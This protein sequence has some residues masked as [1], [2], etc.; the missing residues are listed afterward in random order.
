MKNLSPENKHN[1]SLACRPVIIDKLCLVAYTSSTFRSKCH[2]F[3]G[4]AFVPEPGSPLDLQPN[5]TPATQV[6]Y[7]DGGEHI[8][9]SATYVEY[10]HDIGKVSG[11]KHKKT[12]SLSSLVAYIESRKLNS[13]PRRVR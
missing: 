10:L 11:N 1:G 8:N 2:L 3:K 7:E 12:V 4:S 5:G 9:R 13:Q 6:S